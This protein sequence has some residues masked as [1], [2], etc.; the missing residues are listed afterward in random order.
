MEAADSRRTRSSSPC[1]DELSRYSTTESETVDPQPPDYQRLFRALPSPHLVVTPDLVIVDVNDAY[2]QMLGVGEREGLVGR[3][4]S[5]CSHPRTRGSTNQGAAA[6]SGI[7]AGAGYPAFAPAVRPRRSWS[8]TAGQHR[9]DRRRAYAPHRPGEPGPL[10]TGRGDDRP[11]AGG[12]T[13]AGGR[14]VAQRTWP[15]RPPRCPVDRG[16]HRRPGGCRPADRAPDPRPRA[17]GGGPPAQPADRTTAARP[18]RDRRVLPTGR[19]GEQGV[20]DWYD[21]FI[22]RCGTTMLVI[23]GHRPVRANCRRGGARGH[24]M[25]WA[26]AGHPPPVVINPDGSFAVLADW[27]GDLPLGVD[28]RI[29]RVDQTVT[30][31]RHSTVLLYTDGLIERHRHRPRPRSHPAHHGHHRAARQHLDRPDR[32]RPGPAPGRN[33]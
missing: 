12:W 2:L 5:R 9:A 3:G 21:A 18:R 22:Q 15:G 11:G 14:D 30:L 17:A 16:G 19:S 8:A 24:R 27:K 31:D 1:L 10:G 25:V 32:R 7:P 6:G 20:G 4:S 29:A 13:G 28:P 26:N 23:G 33:P